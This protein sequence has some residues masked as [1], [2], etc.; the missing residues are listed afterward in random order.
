MGSAFLEEVAPAFAAVAAPPPRG[1]AW[2]RDPSVA[3]SR[4]PVDLSHG[5]E[6]WGPDHPG[7]AAG[8]S[9]E[10]ECLSP[11]SELT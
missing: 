8:I 3:R 9:L 5:A 6:P 11:E 4:F 2:K 1:L 7:G 10:Q